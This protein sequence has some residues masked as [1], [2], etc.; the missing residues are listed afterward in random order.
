[1]GRP[2]AARDAVERELL[3][4]EYVGRGIIGSEHFSSAYY[5][6]CGGALVISAYIDGRWRRLPCWLGQVGRLAAELAE[7]AEVYADM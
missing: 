2:V 3:K 5:E 4:K 6:A 7:I 1:M